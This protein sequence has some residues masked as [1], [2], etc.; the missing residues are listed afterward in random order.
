MMSIGN[1]GAWHLGERRDQTGIR[2]RTGS[3]LRRRSHAPYT[4]RNAIFT[5]EIIERCGLLHRRN[6]NIDCIGIAIR[7]ENGARL[8]IEGIDMANAVELLLLERILML[9][10]N[11]FEIVVNRTA[12]NDTRRRGARSS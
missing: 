7:K 4:V 9:L 3:F 12:R 1:I 8:R 2:L 10:D 5:G 6:Q 11:V